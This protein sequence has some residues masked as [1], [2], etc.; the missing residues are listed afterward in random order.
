L[1]YAENTSPDVSPEPARVLPST[2]TVSRLRIAK[3]DPAELR[4]LLS[5]RVPDE[6]A[7]TDMRRLQRGA[8]GQHMVQLRAGS[9]VLDLGARSGL[10]VLHAAVR[11]PSATIVAVE[12]RPRLHAALE[13][14]IRDHDLS[15][16]HLFDAADPAL[17]FVSRRTSILDHVKVDRRQFS[18]ALLERLRR[19]GIGHLGGSF[20]DTQADPIE[21]YRHSKRLA[22][23]FWWSRP[24]ATDP[25]SGR[26]C[27]GPDVSII[28]PAYGV[29]DYLPKCLDSLVNQTILSKEII[30]VDDGSADGSGAVADRWASRYPCVRVI[31][32]ENG[33]CA[34]AR[35]AGLHAARA[36][37][38]GFVDGDD[39]VDLRMFDELYRAAV[40]DNADIAQCEFW[41]VGPGGEPLDEQSDGIARRGLVLKPRHLLVQQPTIWRRLYRARFLKKEKLD[42]A[43]HIKRFDDLPFQFE[44]LTAASRVTSIPERFYYYRLGRP[45]QDIAVRDRRLYM[46]YEIFERLREAVAVRGSSAVETQLRRVEVATH[47]WALGRLEPGLKAAYAW[48]AAAD[49]M[50]HR[51]ILGPISKLKIA[52]TMSFWFTILLMGAAAIHGWRGPVRPSRPLGADREA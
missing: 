21:V 37:F 46:H 44:S 52:S 29:V 41:K 27:Q 20:D 39:W 18:L 49:I 13:E 31:H 8:Y 22:S 47:L 48:T 50:R 40:S 28:V 30:V 12:S 7:T 6:V 35:S 9:F 14:T 23:T 4:R 34:S 32:K 16:I 3:A 19:F 45:E 36:E 26:G 25:V 51:L 38:L 43:V 42:F 1:S 2:A 10:M 11:E 24:G 5:R 33:G 15:N 17:E